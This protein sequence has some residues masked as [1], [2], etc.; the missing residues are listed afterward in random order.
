M[1]WEHSWSIG[2]SIISNR[3]FAPC[4]RTATTSSGPTR[5]FLRLRAIHPVD[6]T[7][8]QHRGESWNL[9]HL[10]LFYASFQ[11]QY[12]KINDIFQWKRRGQNILSKES[13]VWFKVE[14]GKRM[15]VVS[16]FLFLC[17]GNTSSTV[18]LCF[19]MK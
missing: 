19:P 4:P 9:G 12:L 6:V 10:G 11:Q 16:T 17:L 2:V 13:F 1:N 8:L 5:I 14:K 18:I 15:K 7:C 3:Y